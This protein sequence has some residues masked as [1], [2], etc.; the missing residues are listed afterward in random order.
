MGSA[1]ATPRTIEG[2][3]SDLTPD[4]RA[5]VEEEEALLARVL[6]ALRARRPS[7]ARDE[8]ELLERLKEL[9]DLA[10]KAA[11]HDLPTLFQE[12]A[13]VRVLLDHPTD[14]ALPDWRAP[15]F[16]HLRIREDDGVRDYCLGRASFVESTKGVRVVDWRFAPVAR[17]FYRYRQ[18]D[19]YEEEF[20]GRVAE[21]VVE[22]RRVVV[23]RD[24][25][26]TRILGPELALSRDASGR[27]VESAGAATL[28]GGAGTSARAGT[29]GVGYGATAKQGR[30]ADISALLDREQFELLAATGDKPLLVLGSAGSGKT[31]VALHRMATL[32]FEEKARF[33]P[34]R[35]QVVVPERGLARLCEKLLAPLGLG[36]VSI[37]TLDAWAADRFHAAFGTRPPRLCTDTPPAVA[38]LKRHPALY[39]ALG[40]RLLRKQDK[41]PTSL[42]ALRRELAELFTDRSFLGAI[43]QSARG[44]LPTPAIEETVR[45][46]LRQ[47]AAPQDAENAG[48]DPDRLASVD[49]RSISEG[50]PEEIAGTMDVEEIPLLLFLRAGSAAPS[51]A[52]VS[53]LVIDEAEDLSLFELAV[54]GRQLTHERS[55]T[56]A[57]DDAQETLGSF[58]GWGEALAA[59]R[60]PEAR[61]CRL[62]VS[63]RCPLPIAELARQVLGPLAPDSGTLAGRDGAAVGRF[64]FPAE[65]HASLFLVDALRDLL[66]REPH[67]SVGVICRNPETAQVFYRLLEDLPAAKL[68]L[69]G[70][71]SFQPGVDVTDVANVK[72]LE[73][74]YVIVPDAS[75]ATYPH[76][77][78]ARRALHVAVTRASHQLW[79]VSPGAPSPILPRPKEA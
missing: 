74:D 64:E 66:D 4:A 51:G 75:G 15:Y 22:A 30:E 37:K 38:R 61:T 23:M 28:A 21:G 31:T 44:Q 77:D 26:L 16:A 33:P 73:F 27:W 47:I 71:F 2:E 13:L 14:A 25:V 68:V 70:E 11:D 59:L 32:A 53:H 62:Q 3:T 79:I 69:D 72:G 56:L 65:A 76:N 49:G 78:E 43:I 17:V 55:V 46:T 54:L 9:R 41:A 63:Y 52:T 60:T 18:G 19:S 10:A 34:S 6:A 8:Q 20:P 50:T 24:G 57:G 40:Q 39:H 29:L 36:E 67:A 48:T 1:A 5:A 58:A 35:M 42:P 7:R 12:I 45:H